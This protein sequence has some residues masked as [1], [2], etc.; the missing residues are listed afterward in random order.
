MK[1]APAESCGRARGEPGWS[2]GIGR[3]DSGMANPVCEFV[4]R[5]VRDI[6]EFYTAVGSGGEEVT[7][8]VL[9]A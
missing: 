5:G 2:N 1:L 4:Y 8:Q 7:H 9:V 6:D 3:L